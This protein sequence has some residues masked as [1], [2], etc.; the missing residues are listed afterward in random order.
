MSKLHQLEDRYSE[1]KNA[2]FRP[3]KHQEYLSASARLDTPRLDEFSKKC[4]ERALGRSVKVFR[5]LRALP[6]KPK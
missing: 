1:H 4:Y 3:Y 5:K 6:F 2:L